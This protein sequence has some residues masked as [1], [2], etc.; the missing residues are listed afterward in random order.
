M[1]YYLVGEKEK[2]YPLLKKTVEGGLYI[3][4]FEWYKEE[5][6]NDPVIK[7]MLAMQDAKTVVERERFLTIMCGPA[8]PVPDYWR[9]SEAACST[10]EEQRVN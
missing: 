10:I 1:A 3:R 8:N 2:A 6:R 9:P 7:R 5:F 4:T